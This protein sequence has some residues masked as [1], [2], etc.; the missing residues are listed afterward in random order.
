[1]TESAS[2]EGLIRGALVHAT[3]DNDDDELYI[4]CLLLLP[5]VINKDYQL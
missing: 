3:D 4:V 1:V 2:V 5:V